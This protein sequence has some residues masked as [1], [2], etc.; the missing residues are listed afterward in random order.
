[1]P[2]PPVLLIMQYILLVTIQITER[3]SSL[4]LLLNDV[5][6]W[7]C[8]QNKVSILFDVDK[9]LTA[10]LITFNRNITLSPLS[11]IIFPLRK[12]SVHIRKVERKM[13]SFLPLC[14][15]PPASVS[16]SGWL[17]RPRGNNFCAA[18][19]DRGA[20]VWRLGRLRVVRRGRGIS[21]F[22]R[23]PCLNSTLTF[24]LW[25]SEEKFCW[26]DGLENRPVGKTA[27]HGLRAPFAYGT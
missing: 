4:R 2:P 25:C 1:M 12:R 26:K 24:D 6:R 27:S 7:A 8:H 21:E 3:I 16:C 18:R 9:T 17:F 14:I 19:L 22:S 5:W 20:C 10:Y 15:P 13:F 23:P 11:G